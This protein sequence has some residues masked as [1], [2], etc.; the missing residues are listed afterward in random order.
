MIVTIRSYPVRDGLGVSWLRVVSDQSL[1]LSQ[2][3][4]DGRGVS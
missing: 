2:V 4:L 1:S 3:I